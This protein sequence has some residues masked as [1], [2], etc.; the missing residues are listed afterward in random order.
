MYNIIQRT[1]QYISIHSFYR[2]T[3]YSSQIK[4]LLIGWTH[5]YA[6][7]LYQTGNSE[8]PSTDLT[9]LGLEQTILGDLLQVSE[10]RL[11]WISIRLLCSF[12]S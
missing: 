2:V 4:T 1:A 7:R 12:L 11:D 10:D 5:P 8:A 9:L 6:M 3:W